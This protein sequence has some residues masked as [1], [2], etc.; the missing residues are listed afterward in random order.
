[1]QGCEYCRGIFEHDIS[2]P[3]YIPKKPKNYC[4]I[5]KDGIQIGEEYITNMDNEY[6]HWDCVCYGRDLAK[7]L[8]CE[9]KK[10]KNNDE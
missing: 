3:N 5:C 2:C 7:F 8:G 9:I 6:A 1:M 4:F 10:M